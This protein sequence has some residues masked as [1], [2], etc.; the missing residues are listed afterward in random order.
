VLQVEH[1]RWGSGL[2]FRLAFESAPSP[3]DAQDPKDHGPDHLHAPARRLAASDLPSIYPGG[4]SIDVMAQREL[5]VIRKY[6]HRIPAELDKGTLDAAGLPAFLDVGPYGPAHETSGFD[7]LV[8][9]EDAKRA[10]EI[11]GPG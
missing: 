4:Y 6:T 11:L 2:L 10:L 5:V 1:Q 8:R 7:L 9:I 3:H